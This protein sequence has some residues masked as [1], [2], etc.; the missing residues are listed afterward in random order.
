MVREQRLITTFSRGILRIKMNGTESS[1]V[2]LEIWPDNLSAE[3]LAWVKK[4]PVGQ[5]ECIL[6][7]FADFS[8]KKTSFWTKELAEGE[9]ILSASLYEQNF[10]RTAPYLEVQSLRFNSENYIF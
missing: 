8:Q 5:Y 10:Q 6:N 2:Y 9:L 4:L 3:Q 7:S 1:Y